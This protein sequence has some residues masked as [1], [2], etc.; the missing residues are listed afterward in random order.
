M[1]VRCAS[2]ALRASLGSS[3]DCYLPRGNR[4]RL[5][6]MSHPVPPRTQ[7]GGFEVWCC[8]GRYPSGLDPVQTDVRA[9]DDARQSH[10]TQRVVEQNC[11]VL[12]RALANFPSGTSRQSSQCRR[13]NSR[14]CGEIL[15]VDVCRNVSTLRR[16][17]FRASITGYRPQPDS[18]YVSTASRRCEIYQ[19]F[20]IS[21]PPPAVMPLLGLN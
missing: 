17:C 11:I 13:G 14:P 18:F 16:L 19:N 7:H 12:P 5:L 9:Q 6:N 15:A 8:D 1:S 2:H 21:I 3:R 4:F 10:V 20:Q